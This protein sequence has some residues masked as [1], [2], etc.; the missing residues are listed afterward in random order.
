MVH[1]GCCLYFFSGVDAVTLRGVG[2]VVGGVSIVIVVAL[3]VIAIILSSPFKYP[4]FRHSFD[5]T[6]KR[7]P[8]VE[9]E[10]DKWLNLGGFFEIDEHQRKIDAWKARSTEIVENSRL[11]K[12]RQDQYDSCCRAGDSGA[13]IFRL[14]RTQTRYKQVNYV[15]HSYS[16][17]V[18]ISDSAYSFQDLLERYDKLKDIGFEC[19]LSEY[20]TKNQRK[21]MTRSLREQIM[22]RDNYT[23]K[24]CGKYMPDE[25]GLQIDHIVPVAKGGK[26]VPSNL[27]V[28]CSKC[29]GSKSDKM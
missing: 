8:K 12:L 6:N 9:N 18:T 14:E 19:T 4:Y 10:L 24:V 23:C 15:K 5:V 16:A 17:T 25:V 20:E 1:G 7:K 11:R 2:M 26:S 27:Q 28:L 21:L 29:N 13:F 22:R 3:I